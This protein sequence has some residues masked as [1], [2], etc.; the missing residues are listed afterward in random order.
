MTKTLIDIDDELLARARQILGA[1]TK[2]ATV[3]AAL[4]EIVRLWA[5]VEFGHLARSGVFAGQ[6]PAQPEQVLDEPAE[7]PCR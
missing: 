2:K 1:D 7:P 6:L 4:R 3:N 5:V